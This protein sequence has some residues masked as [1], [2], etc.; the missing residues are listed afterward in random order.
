MTFKKKKQEK[1]AIEIIRVLYQQYECCRENMFETRNASFQ[2]AFLDTFSNKLGV[3]ALD[4]PFYSKLCSLFNGLNITLDQSFY[5]SVAHIFS[6]GESR[7]F[8]LKMYGGLKISKT[9]KENANSIIKKLIR[10]ENE[11]DLDY[12]NSQLFFIDDGPLVNA[13]DFSVDVFINDPERIIAVNLKALR[14]NSFEI[15]DEKQKILEGKAALYRKFPDKQIEFY[16]GFPFDPTHDPNDPT[17]YDKIRFMKSC[18]NMN[19]Y[20]AESEI[21]IARELWDF[22]SGD[23]NTMEQ[24]LEMINEISTIDFMENY[25][26]L[27]SEENR[28]FQ[29]YSELLQKWYL[30]SEKELI[31]ND[32]VIKEKIKFDTRAKRIYNQRSFKNGKYDFDRYN[33]LK[34]LI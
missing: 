28:T 26:F 17:G 6:N 20:F 2:R 8:S 27:E 23:K 32:G 15:F 14:P 7:E 18:K 33:F 30:Y 16:L 29:K 3:K 1:I 11:P 4:I 10:G 24:L 34:K 31:D 22:L 5:E 12:E 9:Q 13:V 19:K 21:K 25:K